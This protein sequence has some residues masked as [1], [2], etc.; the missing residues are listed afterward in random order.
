VRDLRP[1]IV[2]VL[3]GLNVAWSAGSVT[4]WIDVA[5]V[6]AAAHPNTLRRLDEQA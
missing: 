6:R 3:V 1:Q 2:V 4:R 5:V